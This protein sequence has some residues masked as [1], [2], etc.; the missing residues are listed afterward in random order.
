MTAPVNQRKNIK[1]TT[2]TTFQIGKQQAQLKGT[3]STEI[4]VRNASDSALANLK[5]ASP[6]LPSHAATRAYVDS[7]EG[8]RIVTGGQDTTSLPNNSATLQYKVGFNGV[9]NPAD[10]TLTYDNGENDGNP[11]TVLAAKDGRSIVTQAGFTAGTTTF[12]PYSQY[13]WNTGTSAWVKTGDI[14]SVTNAVKSIEMPFSGTAS[15]DSTELIPAGS[16]VLRCDVDVAVAYP[17][18]VTMQVGIAGELDKF[19]GASQNDLQE[20]G[21]N[22]VDQRTELVTDQAVRFT[23][24]G[25]PLT[26]SGKLIVEYTTPKA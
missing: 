4:E 16:R 1:G 24:T 22:Q 11:V 7:I 15:V 21:Y 14:G 2:S 10:G 25:A 23:I 17:V 26:G 6:I 19:M 5:V 8:D 13:I 9:G 20:V 12:D 18:G 3:S